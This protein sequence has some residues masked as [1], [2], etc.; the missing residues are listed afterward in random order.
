MN[1]LWSFHN[2]CKSNPHT[3]YS[4]VFQYFLSKTGKKDW[5][6]KQSQSFYENMFYSLI[7]EGK[8][9]SPL[10]APTEEDS[11]YNLGKYWFRVWTVHC[12]LSP[13]IEHC[14][15]NFLLFASPENVTNSKVRMRFGELRSSLATKPEEIKIQR[16]HHSRYTQEVVYF[17]GTRMWVL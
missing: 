14:N 17:L 15:W 11:W 12:L 8:K 7:V 4:D 1:L 5:K 2:T 10:P 16:Y 13:G 9:Y 3:L 6:L